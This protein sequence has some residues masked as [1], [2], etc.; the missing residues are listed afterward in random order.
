MSLY[1]SGGY[2]NLNYKQLE[3]GLTSC[4]TAYLRTFRI[5]AYNSVDLRCLRTTVLRQA[6]EQ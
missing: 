1:S 2:F 4:Q 3:T 5:K 6:L